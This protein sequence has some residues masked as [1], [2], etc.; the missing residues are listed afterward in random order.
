MQISLLRYERGEC[1]C[2]HVTKCAFQGDVGDK[3]YVIIEGK[4]IV[5]RDRTVLCVL[6]P[7]DY[8]GEVRLFDTVKCY[9]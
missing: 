7:G 5:R 1:W 3:M 9:Q 6:E 8:F 4:A 2:F